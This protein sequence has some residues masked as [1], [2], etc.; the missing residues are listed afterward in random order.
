VMWDAVTGQDRAIAVLDAAS[1]RPGHAYLLVGALGSGVLE[2]ARLFAARLATGDE[3]D[4]RVV[5]LVRR[6]LFA[7]V[8]EFE[9]EGTMFLVDQSKAVLQEASRAPVEGVRKVLVLHDVD[10]MNEASS[11]TLLKTIEEPPAR[12]AFVLTTSRPDE[13]LETVRSRCQRIDFDTLSDAAVRDALVADGCDVVAAERGAR[14]AGGHLQRA[15]MLTGQWAPVHAVLA[16]APSR[17]DGTGATAM[18]IIVELEDALDEVSRA[19]ETRHGDALREFD[20]EMER[21]GYEPRIAQARRRRLAERHKRELTRLRRDLLLEGV[22]ATEAVYRDALDPERHGAVE[23]GPVPAVTPV[24]ASRALH[25]CRVAREAILANE[26]GALHTL[27]LLLSL[28]V[29][30][31]R[32][33][34]G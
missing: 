22:T 32:A 17:V 27:R 15:R 16:A 29:P 11:S 12:T 33:R 19:T 13:V 5:D 14:L 31:G 7:D 26:K 2:A 18:A 4:S 10:R 6:G 28:P 20:A 8:V 23:V 1:T 21:L 3:P 25:A 24:Q 9:P 30:R 34:G